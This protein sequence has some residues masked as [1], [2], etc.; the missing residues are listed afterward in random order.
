MSP[1]SQKPGH[2]AHDCMAPAPIML[3]LLLLQL[4]IVNWSHYSKRVLGCTCIVFS[5]VWD[6]GGAQQGDCHGSS[7][8]IRVLGGWRGFGCLALGTWHY[9]D[10]HHYSHEGDWNSWLMMPL[11]LWVNYCHVS[12]LLSSGCILA[13]SF[14]LFFLLSWVMLMTSYIT[15]S[16]D[17]SSL[18]HLCCTTYIVPFNS[19]SNS[20]VLSI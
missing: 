8:L 3:K 17:P 9:Q 10:I 2:F 15:Q 5:C 16:C 19:L 14:V 1:C 18:H 11:Q 12:I 20:L 6:G 13:A 4:P 7:L